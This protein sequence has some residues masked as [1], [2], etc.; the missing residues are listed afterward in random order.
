MSRSDD[1]NQFYETLKYLHQRVGGYRYLRDCTA[2][3]GWPQRGVYFFLENGEIRADGSML[4][5]TRVG[6]HAVSA[7][8]RTTLWSRLYTHRGPSDGRGNHRGSVFR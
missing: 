7:N 5:V 6:T 8:S 1:V 2:K 3:S 4:R